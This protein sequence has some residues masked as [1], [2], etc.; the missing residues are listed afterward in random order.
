V[1][2]T[3]NVLKEGCLMRKKWSFFVS[4]MMAA[5][6]I[7]AGCSGESSS[8]NSNP[9]AAETSAQAP[10]SGENVVNIEASNWKFN[11]EK[12][13]VKAGSPV[14]I[15]FKSTEGVHGISIEGLDVD[16]E[17]EGSKTITPDKP[18]EY[19]IVCNIMCGPDHGKMTATLVVK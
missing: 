18:G 11:Q 8:G 4:S 10:A 12:Y 5:S 9:A 2:E 16:I 14:T 17:R 19:K 15:N 3:K 1:V 6:L 7:F 13:E